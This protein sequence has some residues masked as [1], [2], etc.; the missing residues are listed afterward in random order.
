MYV[1]EKNSG[2]QVH[3]VLFSTNLSVDPTACRRPPWF[4]ESSWHGALC[5]HVLRIKRGGGKVTQTFTIFVVSLAASKREDWI[6][7]TAA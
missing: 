3:R 7:R 2:V 4:G 5:R 1:T 6:A